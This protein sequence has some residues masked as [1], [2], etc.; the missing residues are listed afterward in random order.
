M[1][2]GGL[3][4]PPA[5]TTTNA[6]PSPVARQMSYRSL[7]RW[8]SEVV[9]TAPGPFAAS[10]LATLTATL[11][12]Q[13]STLVVGDILDGVSKGTDP[14]LGRRAILYAVLVLAL[15]VTRFGGRILVGWSETR[16]ISQLQQTLHDKLLRLGAGFHERHE[17]GETSAIVLQF[18][19]G[20]AE[21]LRDFA[22]FPI[23]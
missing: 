5:R 2:A 14:S 18:S 17:F 9:A 22:A 10:V 19:G 16:M 8:S 6:A 20:A 23:L 13:F 3:E 12:T 7:I 4:A 1:P 21:M 11:L 15:I